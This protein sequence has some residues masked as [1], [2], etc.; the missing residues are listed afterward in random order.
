MSIT[1]DTL[2]KERILK[3][4]IDQHDAPYRAF[5]DTELSEEFRER[6][7]THIVGFEIR[8]ARLESKFKVSQNR[9]PADR[10]GVLAAMQSGDAASRELGEWMQR[11]IPS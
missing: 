10:A 6:H 4:L 2:A 11:L 8:V 3:A 5:W 9:L 7:K 1:H